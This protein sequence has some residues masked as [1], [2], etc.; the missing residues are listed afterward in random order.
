MCEKPECL[1]NFDCK[2]GYVC[3]S[4]Q[5]VPDFPCTEDS[6]CV[7][8]FTRTLIT[9]EGQVMMT[10]RCIQED[11]VP[12]C[13]CPGGYFC[14]EKV[15]F[16]Y[17]Y[18]TGDNMCINGKYQQHCFQGRCTPIACYVDSDC[19]TG[20]FCLHYGSSGG[21]GIC[22]I[23]FNQRNTTCTDYSNCT[24]GQICDKKQGIC[25]D[26]RCPPGCSNCDENGSCLDF[27]N[28]DFPCPSGFDC[29]GRVCTQ[30]P[31][32][33][34]KCDE[35]GPVKCKLDSHCP[36]S[37]KCDTEQSLCIRPPPCVRDYHCK[38]GFHCIKKQCEYPPSCWRNSDC[39]KNEICIVMGSRRICVRCDKDNPA[40]QTCN[41]DQDCAWDE[42]CVAVS[43]NPPLFYCQRRIQREC[44]FNSHCQYNERCDIYTRRCVAISWCQSDSECPR[45]ICDRVSHVC[46][47]Q[48]SAC[49]SFFELE[50]KPNPQCLFVC[51]DDSQCR[52]YMGYQYVCKEERCRPPD[53][54][55]SKEGCP[56]GTACTKS[57][58]CQLINRKYTCEK[59]EECGFG[60]SCRPA[61]DNDPESDKTSICQRV[62]YNDGMCPK[63]KRCLYGTCWDQCFAC[64]S[65]YICLRTLCVLKPDICTK[66][67]GMQ[68]TNGICHP[69]I[70]CQEETNCPPFMTCDQEKQLCQPD[71][72]ENTTVVVGITCVSKEDCLSFPTCQNGNCECLFGKCLQ[73]CR[74]E[75]C[76]GRTICEAYKGLKI[77]I[78]DQVGP[79][80][81]CP[82]EGMLIRDGKCR[83]PF[84]ISH[85][86]CEDQICLHGECREIPK[87]CY[88]G[89]PCGPGLVCKLG[90]CF[91]ERLVC[92][93]DSDCWLHSDSI[94]SNGF[95]I[96]KI[97]GGCPM[98]METGPDGKCRDIVCKGNEDCGPEL[99]C[100]KEPAQ[101]YG[102]CI[103][104][105]T[106]PPIY[107]KCSQSQYMVNGKCVKIECFQDSHCNFNDYCFLGSCKPRDPECSDKVRHVNYTDAYQF[108]F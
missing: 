49:P 84:C 81:R 104:K 90:Y 35:N 29:K 21:Q 28:P 65:D 78:P 12:S 86:D 95:C 43:K 88:E 51:K 96:P 57:G 13:P 56:P 105:I 2:S 47:E 26:T 103:N 17:I 24:M 107:E 80:E 76:Q 59:N 15:C 4:N 83:F 37:Q 6:H 89:S 102:I 36:G 18:C 92:R 101:M 11:C 5:C 68:V 30:P 77:C 58:D 40:C 69:E 32:K 38:K 19:D 87:S 48:P 97:H 67:K 55:T 54:S 85:M 71:K 66:Y 14:M 41:D 16:R 10:R 33:G 22:R 53:C 8:I 42:S 60:G 64:K 27:C 108:N 61:M 34:P 94:C 9:S 3:E 23:Q 100:M 44:W 7:K 45:G 25:K 62:C 20:Y 1:T 99:N 93:V 70:F 52:K 31:C 106:I 82:F 72:E 46:V 91:N 98:G 63:N 75:N 74:L 79:P 73:S 39:D 50:A